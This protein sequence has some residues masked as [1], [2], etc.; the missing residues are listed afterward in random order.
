MITEI[1]LM[2]EIEIMDTTQEETLHIMAA[3]IKLE[4]YKN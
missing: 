2:I 1:M 4:E 3:K